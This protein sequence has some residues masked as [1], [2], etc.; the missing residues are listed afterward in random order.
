MS[1]ESI[2]TPLGSGGGS[3]GCGGGTT[4]DNKNVV[5]ILGQQYKILYQDEKE[6]PKLE[7]SNGV[8]EFY[9]KEIVICDDAERNSH[10]MCVN[11]VEEFQQKVLRHEII[12]AFAYESGLASSSE[13]AENEEMIDWIAIQIPKMVAAMKKTGAL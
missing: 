8:I 6:N 1:R 9:S 13:W 3:A 12:H 11:K 4:T 2:A 5:E 7:N 10:V